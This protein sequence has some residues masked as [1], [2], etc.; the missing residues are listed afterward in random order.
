MTIKAHSSSLIEYSLLSLKKVKSSNAD[1]DPLLSLSSLMN[2][3]Y[4]AKSLIEL[5]LY[6]LFS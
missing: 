3:E 4:G 6:L 2:A 1:I 5:N